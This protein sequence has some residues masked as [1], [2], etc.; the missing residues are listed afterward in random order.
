MVFLRTEC[1]S[2]ASTTGLKLEAA[3][4]EA[5]DSSTAQTFPPELASFVVIPL[6]RPAL[7]TREPAAA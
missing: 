2:I 1:Y 7:R 5:V 3:G 6:P 4:F